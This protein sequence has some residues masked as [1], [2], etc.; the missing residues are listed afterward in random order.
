MYLLGD[1]KMI[2]FEESGMKFAFPK[3]DTY[4]VENASRCRNKNGISSVECI[5][6]HKCLVKFIEAKNTTPNKNKDGICDTSSDFVEYIDSLVNKINDSLSVLMAEFH[7]INF[8]TTRNEHDIIGENLRTALTDNPKMM[9][10]LIIKDSEIEWCQPVQEELNQRLYKLMK[11][12]QL[13][14]SVVN[15]EMARKYKLLAHN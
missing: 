4:W 9:Y 6:L 13:K 10:V 11:I 2:T 3:E 12:W 1:R 15:E 7:H 14:V 5:V 8:N